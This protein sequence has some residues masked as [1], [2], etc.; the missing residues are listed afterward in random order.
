MNFIGN[1]GF[2]VLIGYFFFSAAVSGMPEPTATSGLA[3]RWAYNSLHALAGDL[4][5][6]IGSRIPKP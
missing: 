3:Y 2:A 5:R 4:S 6:Q 1:H